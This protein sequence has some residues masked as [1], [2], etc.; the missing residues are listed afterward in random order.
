[1]RR[2]LV[3]LILIVPLVA[4]DKKPERKPSLPLKP[5]RKI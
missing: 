5:E 3:G 1:M 4:Q 2:I